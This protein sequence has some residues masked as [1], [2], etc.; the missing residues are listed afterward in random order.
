[1]DRPGRRVGSGRRHRVGRTPGIRSIDVG[2]ASTRG[3][4]STGGRSASRWGKGGHL[5]EE[6]KWWEG[7][8]GRSWW[9]KR[10]MRWR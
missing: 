2:G 6:G 9:G 8:R 5:S 1:M 7:G 3:R 10:G 4:S